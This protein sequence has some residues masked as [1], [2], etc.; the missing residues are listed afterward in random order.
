MS[1]ADRVKAL[2]YK[3]D[4]TQKKFA[5]SIGISPARLNNYLAG[6]SKVPQ[7][8]LVKIS[9]TYNVN[10]SWLITGKGPMFQELQPIDSS[11]LTKTI[12]L[13]I[14]GEIAAGQPS[15]VYLDEPLGH[16]DLPISFLHYP[17]PY[18]VFRVSGKSM[19]PYILSG[20]IVVCSQDWRDVNING[21]IMAFR[22]R[23]GITIKLL[24]EDYK[25]KT[26]WLMPINHD[27]TPLPFNE[28]TEDI[29]MIGI[30]DIAIRSYNRE[31]IYIR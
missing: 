21:K 6:L 7:D 3:K 23:E 22:T 31:D 27:F 1:V 20:D 5:E 17:P 14:V 10:I 26:T 25:N 24:V 9:D 19:E 12:R 16:I 18:M 13:P 30:L 4:M 11:V 8:I 2:I 28:D 29:T 15:E